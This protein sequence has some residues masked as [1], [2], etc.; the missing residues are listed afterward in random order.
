MLPTNPANRTICLPILHTTYNDE[1]KGDHM[2]KTLLLAFLISTC[3]QLPSY[4]DTL[5]EPG[6]GSAEEEIE[7]NLLTESELDYVESVPAVNAADGEGSGTG[8][9][10]PAVNRHE[11]H[12]HLGTFKLTA[13]CECAA[14]NGRWVA[15]PTKS[16]TDYVEG[17]TIA[18]DP[19]VIPLGS[20]VEI[21][22]PGAGWCR[23][24]A[25]DTGSAIKQNRI[26]IFVNGHRNCTLP[27]FNG[28]CEVR[29]VH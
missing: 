12:T 17:R 22:I 18:V 20:I 6:P 3:I 4:A 23:Y 13:F 16:G 11:T 27:Q 9:D 1:K 10:M 7:L 5:T 24:R 25:E 26:D 8:T 19:K 29:L 15:Q 28:H 14:C 2:R 21:N